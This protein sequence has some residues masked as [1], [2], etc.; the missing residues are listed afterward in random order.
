MSILPWSRRR[1]YETSL[2]SSTR[3]RISWRRSASE[4]VDRSGSGSNGSPFARELRRPIERREDQPLLESLDDLSLGLRSRRHAFALHDLLDDVAQL[5][6]Q[7]GRDLLGVALRVEVQ[8]GL[9]RVGQDLHPAALVE[10]LDPVEDVRLP[11]GEALV[12]DAHDEPLER[13]RARQLAVVER[14]RRQLVDELRERLPAGA[15][16]Q[17]EQLAE[18]RDGVVRGQEVREDV[19]AADRAGEHDPVLRGGPRQVGE[20]GGRPHDLEPAPLDHPVDLARDRDRERGAAVAARVAD[21][22]EEEE[23]RLL[24]G[25]LAA[26]LVDEVQALRRAVE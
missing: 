9:V 2:S 12:E 6:L 17:L 24:D 18:A 25:H 20:R 19:A 5:A 13:P 1:W 8:D 3:S 4:S 23:Q 10:D 7:L 16:E 14:R 21:Q 26:A 22:A 11:V 15:R